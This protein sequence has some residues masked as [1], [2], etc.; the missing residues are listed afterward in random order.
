[1]SEAPRR[2]LRFRRPDRAEHIILLSTFTLLAITGLVQK[3]AEAGLSQAIISVLGGIETTRSIHHVAAVVLMLEAIFHLGTVSYKVFVRRTRLDMLPALADASRA[4]A[5][6]LYNLGLRRHPPQEGRYTFA[7]KAEY[8]AVVW[9]TVLMAV[10]GFMMWNPI[11]TTRFLPGQVIPAAK[12]AHGYEAILAALA[13]IIWHMY[14]VHVRRFNRSMFTGHLKE[15]EMLEEHPLELADIK[16]GLAERPVDPKAV[17]RR[18]RVFVPIYAVAAGLLLAGVY[19]FVTFEQTAITTLPEPVDVPV[20]VPLT[21]TPLPTLVPTAIRAATATPVAGATQSATTV[22]TTW[23][24]DIGPL[25]V[26]QCG[27]CHS[28]EGR[29]AGL[30]LTS[31]AGALQGGVS[32][33]AIVPGDPDASLLVQRQLAGDHPGQLS[34]E[35][36]ERVIAWI[37]AGAAE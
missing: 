2:Y 4:W 9:G 1:M 6:F 37:E 14:H 16:A 20:F 17:A 35:D 10:T 34:T 27:T 7:E 15:D 21:P 30:D 28:E 36:L 19:A 3:F 8:F 12:A 24:Q 25:I 26:P 5:A 32:G 22:I 29:M 18:L 11:S 33:P 31:Y 23:R 13:I